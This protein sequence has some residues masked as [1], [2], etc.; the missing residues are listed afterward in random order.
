MNARGA[1]NPKGQRR[2]IWSWLKSKP[3]QLWGFSHLE[4]PFPRLSHRDGDTWTPEERDFLNTVYQGMVEAGIDTPRDEEWVRANAD[5]ILAQY[6][7]YGLMAADAIYRM[8]YREWVE[9]GQRGFWS[10][11]FRSLMR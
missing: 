2:S 8:K 4:K 11:F 7:I 10:R 3:S 1:Q 5:R 9:D 6:R